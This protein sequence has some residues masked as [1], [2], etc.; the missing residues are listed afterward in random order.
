MVAS[1]SGKIKG[2]VVGE[3]RSGSCVGTSATVTPGS[4]VLIIRRRPRVTSEGEKMDIYSNELN[5]AG[6]LIVYKIWYF[7][8]KVFEVVNA[9][10][11]EEY[12]I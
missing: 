5:L 2:V 7:R 12:F 4:A 10:F 3:R 11:H 9:D 1:S 6:D 8:G